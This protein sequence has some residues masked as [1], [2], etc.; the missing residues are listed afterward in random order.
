MGFSWKNTTVIEKEN[1]YMFSKDHLEELKNSAY[2]LLNFTKTK[3]DLLPPFQ[4]VAQM[5]MA[6]RQEGAYA[7]QQATGTEN[8]RKAFQQFY[9]DQLQVNFSE[10]NFTMINSVKNAVFDLS[11]VFL[12]DEDQVLCPNPGN[13]IYP[14]TAKMLGA[15]PVS[16]LLTENTD[17]QPDFEALEK[18][19]LECI[20]LMWIDF[21]QYPIGASFKISVLQKL[22]DFCKKHEIIL[23]N[24]NSHNFTLNEQPQSIFNFCSVNDPVLEIFSLA[25]TFNIGGW[26]IGT[27]VGNTSFIQDFSS[28]K[29]QIDEGASLP[30]QKGVINALQNEK[31]RN[32]IARNNYQYQNRKNKMKTLLQEMDC[33]LV[34]SKALGSFL[35]V[36]ILDAEK[37]SVEFSAEMLKKYSIFVQPGTD[38]GTAGEG[39]V[40][41]TLVEVES[42]I[43]EAINRI[44]TEKNN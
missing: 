42:K 30:C 9:K 22:I 10:E 37:T 16:Y 17:W 14:N 34:V 1:G 7:P 33:K 15:N 8:L 24:N 41:A 35:W 20:K 39:Y 12:S 43:E 44:K 40:F 21:S 31:E 23:I 5:Q 18:Q 38:F 29:N 28:F 26:Q 19:D 2:P 36:K 6:T 32:F 25:E 4:A 27:L 3:T 11:F 13:P